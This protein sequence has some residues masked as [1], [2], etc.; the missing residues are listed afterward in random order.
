[1]LTDPHM[2]PNPIFLELFL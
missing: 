1:M 2:S